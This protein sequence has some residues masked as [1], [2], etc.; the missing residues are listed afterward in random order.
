MFF[1]VNWMKG[2]MIVNCEIIVFLGRV[3]NIVFK[4]FLVLEIVMFWLKIMW[5]GKIL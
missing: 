3:G 4:L 1:Y 5:N 2:W